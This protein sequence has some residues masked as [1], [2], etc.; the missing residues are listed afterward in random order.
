MNFGNREPLATLQPQ[1]GRRPTP[2]PPAL[3]GL[4]CC[5]ASSS[6]TRRSS[7]PT[8]A[9]PHLPQRRATLPGASALSAA[10][11]SRSVLPQRRPVSSSRRRFDRTCQLPS[12]RSGVI[13]ILDAWSHLILGTPSAGRSMSPARRFVRRL[14]FGSV[15]AWRWSPAY[16]SRSS[17]VDGSLL[18]KRERRNP[19]F[20]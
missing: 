17:V 7:G 9:S 15:T 6:R 11:P 20:A 14:P 5:A 1:I 10:E 18:S 16:L 8:R 13:A 3:H 19:W 2:S 4:A 12:K